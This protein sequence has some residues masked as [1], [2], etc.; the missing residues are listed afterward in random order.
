MFSIFFFLHLCSV[1][2]DYCRW[3]FRVYNLVILLYYFLFYN[4]PIFFT[5]LLGVYYSCDYIT[6][7][8]VI[9]VVYGVTISFITNFGLT[10]GL[11]IFIR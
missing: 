10:S 7:F 2:H 3:Y 5:L 11:K 6:V 1:L 4:I 9:C 8:H